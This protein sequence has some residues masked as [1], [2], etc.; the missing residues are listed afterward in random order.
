MG[1]KIAHVEASNVVSS[2]MTSQLSENMPKM[3][4]RNSLKSD[5]LKNLPKGNGSRF[6]KLFESLNLQDIESWND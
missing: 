3:V 2:S 5:L 4:A 6:E 1:T